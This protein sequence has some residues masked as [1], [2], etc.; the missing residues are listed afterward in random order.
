MNGAAGRGHCRSPAHRAGTSAACIRRLAAGLCL[1]LGMLLAPPASAALWGHV[2]GAGVAHFADRPLDARYRWIIGEAGAPSAR[3]VPGKTDGAAGLLLWLDMAPQVK[4]VMPWVRE[5][6][7][8]YRID[9][10][11]LQAVIA[12]ESGFDAGAVSPRGA[13]GLMQITAVAADRYAL[14]DERARPPAQRLLD[15]RLN[16][17]T[18]ARMLADLTRRWQRVDLALAAWNAGEGA[19]RRAGRAM[20][21]NGQ[22]GPHVHLVLELYWAL[23]QQRL[24]E[25]A[26]A[27]RL[28]AAPTR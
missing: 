7:H 26:T 2:D 11:L 3:A 6:A 28:H 12:V 18:G 21:D 1:A 19:V 22:T 25:R 24:G 9:A 17:H 4:A 14:P 5:A 8:L 16:I 20:P 10:E 27:L 15:P 13:F 23:L